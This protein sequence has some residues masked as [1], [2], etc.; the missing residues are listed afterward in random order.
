MVVGS[1]ARGASPHDRGSGT[2]SAARLHC[3]SD[4]RGRSLALLSL[5]PECL[6]GRAQ[7]FSHPDLVRPRHRLKRPTFNFFEIGFMKPMAGPIANFD[8]AALALARRRGRQRVD[9]RAFP[10]GPCG[11]G[12]EQQDERH[13]AADGHDAQQVPCR[14]SHGVFTVTSG[15]FIAHTVKLEAPWPD[16]RVPPIGTPV[17]YPRSTRLFPSPGLSTGP[18]RPKKRTFMRGPLVA[19]VSRAFSPSQIASR[20]F[21]GAQTPVSADRRV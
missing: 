18:N 9:A 5:R 19:N 16:F 6:G 1:R 7:L 10:L 21:A 2:S 4:G 8:G 20:V 15:P 3:R 17:A 12:Q 14:S 11:P 13:E